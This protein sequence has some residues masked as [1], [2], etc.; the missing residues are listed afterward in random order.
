MTR[1]PGM[2]DANT[3]EPVFRRARLDELHEDPANVRRHGERN[4]TVVRASLREFGQV[5]ALVVERGT[6]RVIGG[7]CR[8]G[9]LRALGRE[10]VWIAEVDVHG[11]DAA[12]LGIALNRSAELAA[13]DDGLADVLRGLQA[14][15][16]DL[17]ALGFDDR[18]IERWIGD[19]DEPAPTPPGGASDETDR[20]RE[21]WEIVVT[22]ASEVEQRD[23]LARLTEEGHTCRALIS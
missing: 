8:L 23:L 12:R 16:V 9:E 19:E 4:R 18:D 21:R 6:G 2:Q 15:D 11:I 13:W 3:R 1:A 7:N 22:C 5:E 10:E 20:L 17:E 14:D